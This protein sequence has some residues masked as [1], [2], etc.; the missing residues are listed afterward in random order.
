MNACPDSVF[1]N[2][3]KWTP[4]LLVALEQLPALAK[5]SQ[6]QVTV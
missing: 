1:T 6:F 3:L 4:L 5:K 2:T